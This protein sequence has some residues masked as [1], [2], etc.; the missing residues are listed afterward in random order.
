MSR[1]TFP[2]GICA[3]HVT[4]YSKPGKFI[5]PL[6][7]RHNFAEDVVELAVFSKRFQFRHRKMGAN[8]GVLRTRQNIEWVVNVPHAVLVCLCHA[9]IKEQIVHTKCH[10]INC[11][12]NNIL[13]S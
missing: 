4:W 8:L 10:K 9:N 11:R 2:N 7:A 5:P 13:R 12:S 1:H 6:V 3:E